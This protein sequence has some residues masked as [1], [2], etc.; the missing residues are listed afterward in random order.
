V[1]RVGVGLDANAEEWGR[2]LRLDVGEVALH[3]VEAGVRGAR[4]LV[5]LLHGF[6]EFWWSWRHQIRALAAAGY[7]VVA[8]DLRGYHLSDQ[9]RA[10]SAYRLERLEADV[11]GLIRACGAASA[12]VVGHD[13]GGVI[14]WSFA[15]HHAES[16]DRLVI[17]NAPHPRRMVEGL[18]TARQLRKSWYMFFFQL[19]WLPERLLS[20]DDYQLVQRMFER[21]GMSLADAAR[22]AA[23]AKRT[24]GLSGG[25]NYYRAAFHRTRRGNRPRRQRVEM[26]TLVIWG[27]KDRFLGKELAV[28]DPQH[29]P[30]A[31]VEFIPQAS[32]WVQHDAPERVNELLLAFLPAA[33]RAP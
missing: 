20:R 10:V 18:R 21:D 28:P 25:V 17:L 9:P 11:A 12:V 1:T 16:V 7:H 31:R 3:V 19:P 6:P 29:V 24:A 32:H 22:Y 2:S 30:N 33:V 4:P 13:W 27:E 8:P 23:A 15:R 14:A 5:V 26:P